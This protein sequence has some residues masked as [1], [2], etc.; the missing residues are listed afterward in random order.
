[1]SQDAHDGIYCEEAQLIYSDG[2]KSYYVYEDNNGSLLFEES[3]SAAFTAWTA[4][5]LAATAR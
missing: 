2:S 3:D 1:M 4:P 5:I